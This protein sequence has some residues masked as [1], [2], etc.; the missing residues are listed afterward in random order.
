[1]S[2]T[3]AGGADD[4]SLLA[5]AARFRVPIRAAIDDL[6]LIAECSLPDEWE[7]KVLYLPL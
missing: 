1:V 4:P 5:W 7:G 3:S 6:V 2:K